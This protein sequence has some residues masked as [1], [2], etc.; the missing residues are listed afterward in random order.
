MAGSVL[1]FDHVDDQ[2]AW[3]GTVGVTLFGEQA[4]VSLPQALVP[5]FDQVNAAASEALARIVRHQDGSARTQLAQKM[6]VVTHTPA[7]IIEWKQFYSRITQRLANG[8]L[9]KARV[10]KVL[11]ARRLSLVP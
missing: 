6:S 1:P 11:A 10:N 9:N 2:A 4:L 3:C 8:K 7:E 5:V